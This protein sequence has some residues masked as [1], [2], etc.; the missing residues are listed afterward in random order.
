[1]ER[2]RRDAAEDE[3]GGKPTDD[4]GPP[5]EALSAAGTTP[6]ETEA[7]RSGRDAQPSVGGPKLSPPSATAQ[8]GAESHPASPTDRGR[9][10]GASNEPVSSPPADAAQR[11]STRQA[12]AAEATAQR[13]TPGQRLAAK[14]AAKAAAKALRRGRSAEVVQQKA[15]ARAAGA[16]DWLER[17]RR[18]VLLALGAAMLVGI[19]AVVMHVRERA[20]A[21]EVSGALQ[22][23]L[24][25]ARASIGGGG[26]AGEAAQG[27]R[28][29]SIEA[30]SRAVAQ[31]AAAAAEA[32]QGSVA[33]AYASLIQGRALLDLGEVDRAREAFERALATSGG[34]TLLEWR[35]IEGLAFADE[36][37]EQWSQAESRFRELRTRAGDGPLRFVAEYHLAR[38]AARRGDADRARESLRTLIA[39]LDEDEARAE[40]LPFVR[41]QAARRLAELD[42][43]QIQRLARDSWSGAADGFDP[44]EMRRILEQLRASG[45]GGD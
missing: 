23:V 26:P 3:T 7:E 35:A 2:E 31:K 5:A 1:M 32:H 42:P 21:A 16:V 25:T 4:A 33:G 36:A 15:L 30:R 20:R 38:L 22:P 14:K 6:S 28:F 39:S 29:D 27:L 43:S 13:M 8:K 40:Q 11:G 41:Q 37:R 18:P 34:D 9:E 17:H 10:A 24:E 12:T 44:E 19:V 45:A